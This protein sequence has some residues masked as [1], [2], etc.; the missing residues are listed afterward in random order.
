MKNFCVLPFNSVSISATG[1]LRQCCNGGHKGF[2]TYIQDLNVHQIINNDAIVSMRKNFLADN[3]DSG[4]ERCWEI[5]RIGNRSFRH[6]ANDNK[7]YGLNSH[8]PIKKSEIIDF[9]DIQYV[10]ITLGNKCN[11]ACRMCNP[12]SSSLLAKNLKEMKLSDMDNPLIDFDRQT[13][14]K[15]LDLFSRAKNLTTVY[16]LGG[17]PLINDFH[18][19]IVNLLIAEGRAKDVTIQYSTNLQIDIEKYLELWTNFKFVDLNISIDGCDEVYEYVRWPGKWEKIYK[20]LGRACEFRKNGNFYPTIATT[21]Q[22]LNA[23]NMFDLIEKCSTINETYLPF[24]FIPV[25]GGNY[26]HLTPTE[27][28]KNEVEKLKKLPD[29]YG[30]VGELIQHYNDNI[31]KSVKF[32]ANELVEFFNKQKQFDEFRNQNLFKTLPYFIDLAKK[33]NIQLW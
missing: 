4:C 21:I 7:N 31:V 2:Q 14:D 32:P 6:T 13:K 16:M 30:R 26:L 33:V 12:Y 18:D 23:S 5:E 8:I 22:N 10:D 9:E 1:E 29:P 11:L 24:Y 28:L 27:V 15:I 25:T 17:E 3:K 19:E 20:N